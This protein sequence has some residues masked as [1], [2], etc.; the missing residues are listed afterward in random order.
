M[1]GGWEGRERKRGSCVVS[2]YV[3]RL[4]ELQSPLSEQVLTTWRP[5][6][7]PLTLFFSLRWWNGQ[8]GA[9][10]SLPLTAG[11]IIFPA[12]TPKTH[13]A[14]LIKPCWRDTAKITHTSAYYTHRHT[15]AHTHTHT[16]T[17]S[18]PDYL[19]VKQ[20]EKNFCMN[21]I[22]LAICVKQAFV[23]SLLSLV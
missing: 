16:H 10:P 13:D 18:Q 23:S 3:K 17:L 12:H 14:I 22:L 19:V 15:H 8:C 4:A 6:S 5:P 20:K 11:I 9:G 7:L 2:L 1:K 21:Y